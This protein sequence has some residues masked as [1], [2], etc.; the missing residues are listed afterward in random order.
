MK[1]FLFIRWVRKLQT[2]GKA[3]TTIKSYL[4]SVKSFCRIL[5][6]EEREEM[7]SVHTDAVKTS[8]EPHKRH[9]NSS[10]GGPVCKEFSVFNLHKITCNPGFV[11]NEHHFTDGAIT[12]EELQSFQQLRIPVAPRVKTPLIRNEI[13]TVLFK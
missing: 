5:E 3:P 9:N 13:K 6:R 7:T 8:Q 4:L 10:A 2:P 1:S 11:Y 12:E